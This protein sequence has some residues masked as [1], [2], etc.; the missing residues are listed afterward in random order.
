MTWKS[1]LYILNTAALGLVYYSTLIYSCVKSFVPLIRSNS[2]YTRFLL[3]IFSHGFKNPRRLNRRRA[4]TSHSNTMWRVDLSFSLHNLQTG[5]SLKM[6]IVSRCFLRF[7]LPDISPVTALICVLLNSRTS[8]AS[9]WDGLHIISLLCLWP[10][11]LIQCI[12]CCSLMHAEINLQSVVLVIPDT[13]SGSVS[14]FSD[15]SLAKV[16]AFSLP[17]IPRCPGTHTSFTLLR[18]TGYIRFCLHS[19][20][21]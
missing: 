8:A 11:M 12:W 10:A 17:S 20:T 13:G 14:V 9:D 1:V 3:G 6:T 19:Q 15:L 16:S 4:S 2:L 7:Q 18:L 5:V 21:S